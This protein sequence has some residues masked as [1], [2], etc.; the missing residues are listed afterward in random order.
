MTRRILLLGAAFTVASIIRGAEAPP[1]LPAYQPEVKIAGT[2]TS[3]GHVFMKDA[4]KKW[5]EGFRKFHPD[6]RFVDNL[7]SSAAATGALFTGTA[8][9]GFVGREIRPMEVAGYNRVMK[10]KPF[11][12]QVM[13][14]ALTNPDKSVALGIFVHRDNPLARLTFSQLDAIFG[15]EHLRGA[16]RNIRAWD[17]VGLT[18]EWADRPIRIYQ[19]VLDASPAFYFSVEVMKG[20]LLWNENTRVFDDLDQP[21]GKTV[22]AAQQI[23]D[24]LAADRYGIALAGVG[25]PNPGVKL[26]AIARA[27]GGPWVEPTTENILNRSYPFAR[28]VWIY[29][30]RAPGQPLEPKVREFL[31]YILSREGQQDVAREGDYLPLTAGLAQAETKKLD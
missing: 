20:S 10:H 18:G 5:E 12:V 22:T 13:T 30:N 29:V 26:I 21:G 27:D 3:W 15:A 25:T 7:V 6:V 28:S 8:D 9:L 24:A 1:T 4:M 2:I 23:V 17:Q 16:P 14:G 11:G 31:R 19:G